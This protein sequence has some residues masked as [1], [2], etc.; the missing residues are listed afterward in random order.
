MSQKRK[1][2]ENG[3]SETIKCYKNL[4]FKN[5]LMPA[6]LQWTAFAIDVLTYLKRLSKLGIQSVMCKF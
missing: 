5:N 3:M 6:A 1:C 4:N 2:Y